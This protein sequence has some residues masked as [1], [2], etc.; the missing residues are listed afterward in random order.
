MYISEDYN[1]NHSKQ[2]QQRDKNINAFEITRY[3]DYDLLRYKAWRKKRADDEFQMKSLI[4][5]LLNY[6]KVSAIFHVT[7]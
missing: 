3:Y 5:S 7:S 1:I 4:L 6:D 2:H